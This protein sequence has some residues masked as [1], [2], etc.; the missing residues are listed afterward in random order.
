LARAHWQR[1]SASSLAS[2]QNVLSR[3]GL[4]LRITGG[5][6]AAEAACT[7]KLFHFLS[8]VR[9]RD[10]FDILWRVRNWIGNSIFIAGFSGA[11]IAPGSLI[12]RHK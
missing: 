7:R 12:T 9:T 4:L 2:P 5:A 8:R 11:I 1:T 3:S 10:I 6:L